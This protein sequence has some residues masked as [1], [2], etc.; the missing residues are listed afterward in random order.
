MAHNVPFKLQ[1]KLDVLPNVFCVLRSRPPTFAPIYIANIPRNWDCTHERNLQSSQVVQKMNI[2]ALL[3]ASWRSLPKLLKR[4]ILGHAERHRQEFLLHF[5]VQAKVYQS[6]F[7]EEKVEET[8]GNFLTAPIVA[9]KR[10]FS[11]QSI[12]RPGWGG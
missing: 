11:A 12:R 2:N 9:T 7:L 8:A 10:Q 1:Y 6:R 5:N 3:V 4:S